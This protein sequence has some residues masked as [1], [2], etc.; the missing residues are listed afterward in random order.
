MS[1]DRDRPTTRRDVLDRH[2]MSGY[3]MPAPENVRDVFEGT[4]VDSLAFVFRQLEE[5]GIGRAE[6]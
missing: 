5:M 6:R 1:E 2:G 4:M 3:H